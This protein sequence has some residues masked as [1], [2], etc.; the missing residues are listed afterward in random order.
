M[1]GLCEAA[2]RHGNGV[3][4][5]T[6]RGS[7]QIRGLTERSAARFAAAVDALGIAVRTGVPVQTGVLA[8]LDPDEIADPTPLAET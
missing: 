2:L 6:A 3:M 7:L 5:V 1:I 4:E 8:G